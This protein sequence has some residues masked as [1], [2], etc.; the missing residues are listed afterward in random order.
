VSAAEQQQLVDFLNNGGNLYIE[1]TNVADDHAGTALWSLLGADF[2]GAGPL[3]GDIGSMQGEAATFMG[4]KHFGYANNTDA[5]I[6][7]N[8]LNPGSGIL[9]MSSTDPTYGRVVARE[10]GDSRTIVSSV[11]FGALADADALA[12]K[13]NTMMLY[14]SFLTDNTAPTIYS[15]DDAIDLGLT[16]PGMTLSDT[17]YIQNVGRDQLDI[18]SISLTG[19]AF[20]LSAPATASL[21]FG[22]SISLVISYPATASGAFTGSVDIISNDVVNTVLSIPLT[23]SSYYPPTLQAP[24]ELM[25]YAAPGETATATFELSNIG[26]LPLDYW[27]DVRPATR[28]SGGPDDFGYS[29]TDSNEPDG[30]EYVWNDISATGTLL[31]LAGSNSFIEIDLP[32][33]FPFYGDVQQQ[34]KLTSNGYLTF[35]EDG[36]D[37]TNDPIP[38]VVY[39]NNSIF[40][41]WDNMSADFGSLYYLE[42]QAQNRVVIQYTDWTLSSGYGNYT[43]QIHLYNNGTI[44]FYYNHMEGTLTSATIGIEN[45]DGLDGLQIAYNQPYMEDGLAVKISS[46]LDWLLLDAYTGTIEA[47]QSNNVLATFDATSLDAGM[48]NAQIIAHSNDPAQPSITI[49]VTL[50]VAAVSAEETPHASGIVLRNFPNPFNPT[51]TIQFSIPQD[52]GASMAQLQIF[53]SRGQLIR[54]EQMPLD[55]EQTMHSYTWDGT[56]ANRAPMASGLYFYRIKAGNFTASKKMLLMK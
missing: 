20:E 50:E 17:L 25:G 39:P 54:T 28:G 38:N 46:G 34:I 53:N 11:I 23:A 2:I 36:T 21:G 31:D 4:G 19:D 51:T 41:F 9:L 43:F 3:H 16:A 5:D 49:P 13:R 10:N 55:A 18:S 44:Y 33:G 7:S 8:R 37:R 26:E 48:Y 6:Y 30:P 14:L 40:P 32:W 12:T 35:H 42:E 56:D 24:N 1:G 15:S 52:A 45:Q 47:G 22:E 29:W 27:L